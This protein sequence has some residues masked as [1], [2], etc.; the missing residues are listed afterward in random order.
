MFF[1]RAKLL[2]N[3]LL[4]FAVYTIYSTRH[5]DYQATT[6][7]LANPF[8]EIKSKYCFRFKLFY[9]YF[10]VIFLCNSFIFIRSVLKSNHNNLWFFFL[11]MLVYVFTLCLCILNITLQLSTFIIY[12]SK[13]INKVNKQILKHFNSFKCTL[14]HS[15]ILT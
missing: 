5:L 14:A 15:D 1:E 9:N 8:T 12:N 3:W 4:L 10:V 6:A 7:E 2:Y 11:L 13:S